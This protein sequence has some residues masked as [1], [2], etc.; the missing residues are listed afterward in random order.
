[1]GVSHVVC[2]ILVKAYYSLQSS[3]LQQGFCKTCSEVLCVLRFCEG[4][5]FVRENDF[6]L[7]Y[8]DESLCNCTV[9]STVHRSRRE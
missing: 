2:S 3:A 5:S 7:Q 8:V 4:S 6:L 1:M 9:H